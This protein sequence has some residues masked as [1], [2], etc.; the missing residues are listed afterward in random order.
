MNSCI[1]LFDCWLWFQ[2]IC[3]FCCHSYLVLS[4]P[5]QSQCK[6][7]L[8]GR[9]AITMFILSV[10]QLRIQSDPL[11]PLLQSL[12]VHI[13]LYLS[14]LCRHLSIA[15]LHILDYSK[16]SAHDLIYFLSKTR[17]I[18]ILSVGQLRTQSEILSY[19]RIFSA[20]K[21]SLLASS[22]PSSL[23]AGT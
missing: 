18:I 4:Y 2:W 11:H 17:T 23:F 14:F 20:Y 9:L 7:L 15:L 12:L 13:I 16:Y 6:L 1:I 21:V 5:K 22:S 19:W 10:V 3:C 8:V